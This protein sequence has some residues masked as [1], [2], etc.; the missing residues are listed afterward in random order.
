[1]TVNRFSSGHPDPAAGDAGSSTRRLRAVAIVAASTFIWGG[2]LS[3]LDSPVAEA[4]TK[5]GS[6]TPPLNQGSFNL[7]VTAG[8]ISCAQARS[9]LD[10]NFAGKATPTSRNTG[11]VDGY[12]CS[13]NPAGI[14]SETGVLSY[15]EAN[16]VHFELQTP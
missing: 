14:F 8:S 3:V 5:C 9:I 7:V 1:V 11:D 13:G 10:D 2:A 15:C 16:G 4:A 12:S 6:Y